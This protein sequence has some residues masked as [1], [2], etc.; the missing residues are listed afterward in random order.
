MG[1]VII[2]FKDGRKKTIN[3]VKNA[4]IN[5]D[6]TSIDFFEYDGANSNQPLENVSSVVILTKKTVYNSEKSNFENTS[7]TVI[8]YYD[9]NKNSKQPQKF[10]K[11]QVIERID[12]EIVIKQ[13]NGDESV[14]QLDE[15]FMISCVKSRELYNSEKGLIGKRVI[16]PEEELETA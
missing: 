16:Q 10:Q 7:G 9:K 8:I 4:N 2:N 3:N 1:K 12:N 15:I 14:R 13:K 11:T 6:N 5:N